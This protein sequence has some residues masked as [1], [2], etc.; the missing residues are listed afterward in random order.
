ML[1]NLVNSKMLL[2]RFPEKIPIALYLIFFSLVLLVIASIFPFTSNQDINL[3]ISLR[4]KGNW[5]FSQSTDIHFLIIKSFYLILNETI[6]N[7]FQLLRLINFFYL[8]LIIFISYKIIKLKFYDLDVWNSIGAFLISGGV[9]LSVLIIQDQLLSG[10]LNLLILYFLLKSFE[11]NKTANTI[12]M[13]IFTLLALLMGNFYCLVIITLLSLIKIT[14]LKLEKEKRFAIISNIFFIYIAAIT[15]VIISQLNQNQ[16][17][18][19]I[20][21]SP[22]IIIERILYLILTLL[23]IIGIL[24]ISLFFNIF[25]KLNWNKDLLFF[26]FIIKVSIIIFIFS[27]KINLSIIVFVLPLISIYIFRTL[28]FVQ[29]KWTKIVYLPLFFIP[30][31]IIY[32]DTSIYESI[33]NIPLINYVFYTSIILSSLFNPIFSS[34]AQSILNVHKMALF[35]FTMILSLTLGFFYTQY[36]NK[37]LQKVVTKTINEDFQCSIDRS[38]FKFMKNSSPI[39]KLYFHDNVNLNEENMCYIQLT[40]TS[41]TDLPINDINSV[42]KTILDLNEKTFLN[43]NFKKL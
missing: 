26:L 23:P 14:N 24:I 40:F 5:S 18:F 4:E 1:L 2:F 33:D 11:E 12:L 21:Y 10:L 13:N 22:K 42:N 37:L 8:S 31:L 15:L 27:P 17:S 43:I 16:F 20:L 28:E 41:L 39:L 36:N 32:I 9:I 30:F 19:N 3:L 35:S 34:Q 7:N 25:K 6:L 38:K 29:M